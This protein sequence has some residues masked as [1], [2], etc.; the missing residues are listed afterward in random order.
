M[1]EELL[2][3]YVVPLTNSIA[4]ALIDVMFDWERVFLTKP[5]LQSLCWT[6]LA[7]TQIESRPGPGVNLP[8]PVGDIK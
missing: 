2:G 6:A 3:G 7:T 5:D 8:P 4:V 1:K